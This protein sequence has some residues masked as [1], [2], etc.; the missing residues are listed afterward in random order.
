MVLLFVKDLIVAT[1]SQL[2]SLCAG[3]FIFG[4]LIHFLSQF[5]FKSLE[6]AFGSKGVYLVSWLGTPIHELGHA[7][8][9]LVFFHRI[10]KIEFFSP[11]P[12]SG[13]LGYVSHKWNRRN[14]WAVLGNFFIG[15]GPVILGCAVLFALFYLL[16]PGA[17]GVWDSIS[18]RAAAVDKSYL[19]SD[20]LIIIGHSALAMVR[21]IFTVAN[22]AS[23]RLWVFCYLSICVASNIR[24]SPSDLKGT[25]SGLGCVIVPF[26]LMNLVG[27]ITGFGTERLFPFTASSLG[28]VYSLLILALIMV[29]LGFMLT[30]PV[31][32]LYVK[33]KRGYLLRPF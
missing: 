32:A 5:T 2:A 29:L 13:T 7:F 19:I 28:I 15:L 3:A 20:Y 21:L 10:V 17:S 12:I 30:Y 24:L 9:C 16:I 33:I 25:L 26:L 18:L 23:W 14:P 27:L 1:F 6:N 22:L 4:L 11:D 8:F 31:L